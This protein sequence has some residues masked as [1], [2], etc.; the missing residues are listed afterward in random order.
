MSPPMLSRRLGTKTNMVCAI[1]PTSQVFVHEGAFPVSDPRRSFN[2]VKTQKE[3]RG[4][5]AK[6]RITAEPLTQSVSVKTGLGGCRA[7]RGP[8]PDKD[9]TVSLML[10]TNKEQKFGCFLSRPPLVPLSSDSVPVWTGSPRCFM[11][12]GSLNH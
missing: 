10:T 9:E 4:H 12:A 6:I 8:R 2:G 3:P 7:V 11:G 1:A 5:G